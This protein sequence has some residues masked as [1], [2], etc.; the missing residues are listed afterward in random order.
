MI[1]LK[2]IR[3]LLSLDLANCHSCLTSPQAILPLS[4]LA[5]SLLGSLHCG[6][7]CGPI[8]LTI[9]TNKYHIALYHAGRLVSYMTL[10]YFSASIGNIVLSFTGAAYIMG[11]L[12]IAFGCVSYVASSHF[13]WRVS[14]TL[15]SM[16]LS[17]QHRLA[18]PL[19]AFVLGLAA[20]LLPCGWLYSFVIAVSQTK[21]PII[22]AGLMAIFWLG[23]VPALSIMPL[24]LKP[25]FSKL[26]KPLA[27]LIY[28]ATGLFILF[29][30]V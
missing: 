24:A 29:V 26:S 10:G 19:F 5:A 6:L 21:Q 22:S 16:L 9:G 2:A 14:D 12:F 13:K 23:T 18:K 3:R 30:R 7:M 4:I 25:L 27:S 28:I 8:V 1:K 20:I 15:L 17:K 11:A